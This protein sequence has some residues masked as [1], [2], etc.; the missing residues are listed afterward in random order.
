MYTIRKMFKF[1]AA[2]Q[3]ASAYS[4]LCSEQV[5]GHSYRVEIFLTSERLNSD[6]MVI[7]FGQVKAW[8]KDYMDSW[9][10]ALV[11]PASFGNKRI[12]TLRKTNKRLLVM[13]HNPTAERMA[14]DMFFQIE[15]ELSMR[16]IAPT[17]S[18]LKVRV[19][20]TDTGWAEYSR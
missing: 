19:H 12:A 5:H 6:G 1:E 11:V 16:A 9:D 20:E 8:I 3:L 18:L 17:V 14:E 4:K 13:R 7:D 2:H 10:H 15:K